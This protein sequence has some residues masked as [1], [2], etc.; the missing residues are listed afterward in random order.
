M[1]YVDMNILLPFEFTVPVDTDDNEVRDQNVAQ[2]VNE[3]GSRNL[4]DLLA[5]QQIVMFSVTGAWRQRHKVDDYQANAA[6]IKATGVDRI[7]CHVVDDPWA[8]YAWAGWLNCPDIEFVADGNGKLAQRLGVLTDMSVEDC[9]NRAWQYSA[10][11]DNGIVE[12]WNEE[13][14]M[15][16]EEVEPGDLNTDITNATTASDMLEW[17]QSDS[18]GI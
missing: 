2:L 4:R 15:P 13:P 3:L 8:V 9:G 1:A 6:A 16:I 5:D 17:L 10:F 18:S 11:I 14:N 7:I 12:Y